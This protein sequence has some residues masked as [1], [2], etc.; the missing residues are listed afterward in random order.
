MEEDRNEL[1]FFRVAD[2]KN[3]SLADTRFLYFAAVY[4]FV[5]PAKAA[6]QG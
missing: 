6:T 5:N 2:N 1:T 3:F 4:L